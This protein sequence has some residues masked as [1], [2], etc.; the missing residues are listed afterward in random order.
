MKESCRGK[1]I[2]KEFW[3][4]KKV[5]ITGLSGFKGF[6]LYLTLEALGSD[7][8]GISIKNF[9]SEIY[10]KYNKIEK[11]KNHTYLDIRNYGNLK[12]YF[13]KLKPDVVFHLAAQPLVISSEIEP[14]RT[15]E[16][17]IIGTF[18][19]LEIIASSDI[20]VCSVFATTDKVYKYPQ[21]KNVE[22]DPLGSFELYGATKVACE[23]LI[24]SFNENESFINKF[25]VI[26]AGN[27]LGSGDGG[28]N[29]LLTD[30]LNS[31]NSNHDLN[32]RNPNST[33][34]W[35]YVLDSIGGYLLT[36]EFHSKTNNF[37]TFNINNNELN[38]LSVLDIAKTIISKFKSKIDIS[39]NKSKKYKESEKLVIDSS[40]AIKLLGWKC[41]FNL[42]MIAN[43][44]Y[45]WNE[46]KDI[47]VISISK[48]QVDDYLNRFSK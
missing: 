37:E 1:L 14:F 32:I 44:L 2:D 4:N 9:E 45:V 34:P 16:T 24:K 21:N 38:D 29:R 23:E 28:K 10:N 15:V 13:E 12:K 47:D 39:T 18:N 19:L 46:L 20:K 25:S 7:V 36:A 8:Y 26:R 48:K 11:I 17:N 35:Q 33:R 43:E 3:Q 41:F 42:E 31:I 22:S 6:W 5:L 27:V 40:K 30:V